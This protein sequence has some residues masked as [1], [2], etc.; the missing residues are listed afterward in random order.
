MNGKQQKKMANVRE[1]YA[2]ALKKL[3]EADKLEAEGNYQEAFHKYTSGLE[4]LEFSWKYEKN[5]GFKKSI[6]KDLTLY[7]EKA[8]NVKSKTINVAD[9][10]VTQATTSANATDKVKTIQKLPTSSRVTFDMIAGL[11]EAKRNIVDTFVL[12]I[13]A[14]DTYKEYGIKCWKGLLLFGPPGTGKTMF[15]KATACEMNCAFVSVSCSDILTKWVGSSEE[16]VKEL[17]NDARSKAPCIIFMDEIDALLSTRDDSGSSVSQNVKTEFIS[18]IDGVMSDTTKPVF[19]LGATNYPENIDSAMRRRLEKRIYIPL[20]DYNARVSMFKTKLADTIQQVSDEEIGRLSMETDGFSGADIESIMNTAKI[21]KLR[22][23][24]DCKKFVKRAGEDKW[25]IC[26]SQASCDSE[27]TVVKE[28]TF[29]SLGE[30]HVK[31]PPILFCDLEKA[32]KLTKP[33]VDKHT[34]KKYEAYNSEF[35]SN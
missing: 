32:T 5:A 4:L 13:I 9:N 23:L 27:G 2:N 3:G 21:A 24:T 28:C 35:G 26:D 29:Q 6:E 31:R 7:I 11:E 12:P 10:N 20:P 8:E 30:E 19:I 17:F 33:S 22:Q 14:P 18:Q 25:A 15:A 34:I 1:Y 16:K